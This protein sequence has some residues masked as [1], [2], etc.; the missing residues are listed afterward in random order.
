MAASLLLQDGQQLRLLLGGRDL[1]EQGLLQQVL[2]LLQAVGG[3]GW[4]LQAAVGCWVSGGA[5]CCCCC[6]CFYSSSSC[7]CSVHSH[8]PSWS[9]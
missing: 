9:T 3:G 6:S 4:G 1:N 2:L 7:S 5:C 8:A